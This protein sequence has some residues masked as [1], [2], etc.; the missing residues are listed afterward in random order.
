MDRIYKPHTIALA[1]WCILKA[2]G[3]GAE[4]VAE[5]R[6]SHHLLNEFHGVR[7][8]NHNQV[9]RLIKQLLAEGKIRRG[10]VRGV[11]MRT[12]DTYRL[13]EQAHASESGP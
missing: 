10:P 5:V 7:T 3:D 11:G 2:L 12:C 6:E 9:W 4:T 1:K 13:A 8:L